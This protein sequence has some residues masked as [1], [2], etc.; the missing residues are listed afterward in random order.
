MEDC[1][2]ELGWYILQA[3]MCQGSSNVARILKHVGD[4]LLV[5]FQVL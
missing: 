1:E 4:D 5:S 3:V 2:L